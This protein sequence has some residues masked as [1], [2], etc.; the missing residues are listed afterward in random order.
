[1]G[2]V[3]D[4]EEA[5]RARAKREDTIKKAL[6][7]IQSET[8]SIRHAQSAFEIPFSTLQGRLK[9]A[10]PHFIA[11]I[12]QQ[13]LSPTDEKAIVRLITR[14]ENCGLHL[15]LNMYHKQRNLF[16]RKLLVDIG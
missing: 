13:K 10:K 2:R 3:K 11:H 12:A 6:D 9:G 16:Q 1:M 7:A 14:P 15:V 8:M 4:R 5:A